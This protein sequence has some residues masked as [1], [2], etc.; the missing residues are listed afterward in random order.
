MFAGERGS[1]LA[2]GPG[3]DSKW[4]QLRAG[5]GQQDQ[6]P[7]LGAM[8]FLSLHLLGVQAGVEGPQLTPGSAA[9]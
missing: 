1:S 8:I 9:H 4:S 6:T 2:T 5:G 7:T 3:P